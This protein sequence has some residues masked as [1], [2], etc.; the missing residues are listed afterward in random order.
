[1]SQTMTILRVIQLLEDAKELS[2]SKSEEKRLINS[3]IKNFDNENCIREYVTFED[4]D[5]TFRE[6]MNYLRDADEVEI[7]KMIEKLIVKANFESKVTESDILSLLCNEMYNRTKDSISQSRIDMENAKKN[8][9]ES[10]SQMISHMDI[11]P[12]EAHG[13]EDITK[14]V[15]DKTLESIQIFRKVGK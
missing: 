2:N 15:L 6:W 3:F 5:F 13:I 7:N 8:L 9:S 14:A 12:S 11:E 1:M 4:K 10:I